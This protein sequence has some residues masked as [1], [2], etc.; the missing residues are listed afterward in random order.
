VVLA[1]RA[2]QPDPAGP[3]ERGLLQRRQ[4]PEQ[5]RPGQPQRRLVQRRLALVDAEQGNQVRSALPRPE[6]VAD[7][8]QGVTAALQAG[9]QP[10]ALDVPAAFRSTAM[11]RPATSVSTVTVFTV[12]VFF[13]TV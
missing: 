5:L 11:S 7:P 8:G 3:A 12:T 1:V 2:H 4:P 10:Q 13:G 6:Q 9:D